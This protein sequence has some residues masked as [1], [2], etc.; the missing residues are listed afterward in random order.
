MLA[1]CFLFLAISD[2]CA[3]AG[4]YSVTSPDGHVEIRFFEKEKA[5]N[6]EV[7]FRGE[8][9]IEPSRLQFTIDGAEL[10]ADVLP[11]KMTR[12]KVN[13][14]YPWRGGHS[15]AI[16][17]ADTAMIPF[18]NSRAGLG[19]TLE[20]CAANDGVAFRYIVPLDNRTRV[21]D[22]NDSFQ[23]PAGS[24]VWYHNENGHYEGVH[25]KKNWRRS[26]PANGPCR[27]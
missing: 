25:Q 8:S 15:L 14:K 11:G 6:Y 21:P 13:E 3:A 4:S 27:P 18:Q 2:A 20:V 23:L 7:K 10:T 12:S 9:V 24:V 22:E 5:L 16:N 1:G 26:R 19:F 17:R